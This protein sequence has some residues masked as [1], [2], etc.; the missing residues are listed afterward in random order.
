MREQFIN[1]YR[2]PLPIVRMKFIDKTNDSIAIKD[3]DLFFTK[4]SNVLKS[5]TRQSKSSYNSIVVN[6][7]STS[8][9]I[10]FIYLFPVRGSVVNKDENHR[11]HNNL[12]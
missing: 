10:P 6:A 9:I 2:Q 12:L 8:R 7:P 5:P 1:S 4:K 3:T 11:K